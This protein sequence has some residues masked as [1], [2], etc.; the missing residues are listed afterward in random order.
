MARRWALGGGD[1][2]AAGMEIDVTT[3]PPPST[4]LAWLT[5]GRLL[6]AVA[7]LV[8]LAGFLYPFV[9]PAISQSDLTDQAHAGDAPLIVALVTAFAVGAVLMT[10]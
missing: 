9:L 10:L 8:G 1:G 6:L 2:Y 7:S 5:P 3:A 4:A